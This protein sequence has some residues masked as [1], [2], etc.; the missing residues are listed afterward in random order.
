MRKS[1]WLAAILAMT[2]APAWAQIPQNPPVGA[3]PQLAAARAELRQLMQEHPGEAMPDNR[4]ALDTA[5]AQDQGAL[6]KMLASQKD[7]TQVYLDLNWERARIYDGAGFTVSLAYMLD[8][9][10]V[11]PAL[12]ADSA[13]VH[14]DTPDSLRQTAVAFALYNVALVEIDGTRCA[15]P[16]APSHRIDQLIQYGAPIFAYG[17][18]VSDSDKATLVRVAVH[19]ERA[20]ASVRTD[21][22]VLC[23]G[24]LAQIQQGLAANGGKP[25]PQTTVP[26]VVGKTE[27]VPDAP[28]YKPQFVAPE[29]YQPRQRALRATLP[30][31]LQTL[32]ATPTAAIGG[33]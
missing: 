27:T 26:G 9:W 4:A 11:A 2:A 28:G 6:L 32:L 15:D 3:D 22:P 25:L 14:G 10:R 29:V 24:G 18:N 8:L 30:S 17:R 12:P 31:A 21:D 20:T 1:V 16:S 5:L 33:K 23:S 7:P 19:V 13:T